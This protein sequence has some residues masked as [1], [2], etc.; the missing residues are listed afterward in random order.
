LLQRLIE[1]VGADKFPQPLQLDNGTWVAYRLAEMLPM[2]EKLLLLR[3][4]RAESLFNSIKKSI[5]T[6]A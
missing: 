4:T 5:K 1:Q 2:T 6:N 3:A